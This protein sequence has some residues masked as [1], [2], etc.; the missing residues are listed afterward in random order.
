ML[1]NTLNIVSMFLELDCGKTFISSPLPLPPGKSSSVAVLPSKSDTPAIDEISL[2][3]SLAPLL[4]SSCILFLNFNS[5]ICV[6]YG[7]LDFPCELLRDDRYPCKGGTPPFLLIDDIPILCLSLAFDTVI[8][9]L[10]PGDC[11]MPRCV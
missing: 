3:T 2:E 10:S 6:S 4:E 1:L 5:I 8:A 7:V 9:L 11:S